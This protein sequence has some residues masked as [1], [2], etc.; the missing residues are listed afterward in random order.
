MERFEQDKRTEQRNNEILFGED[1]Q[2]SL[3]AFGTQAVMICRTS[4]LDN[5]EISLLTSP[6]SLGTSS[7]SP[8]TSTDSLGT[9]TDSLLTSTDSLLTSSDS[10]LTKQT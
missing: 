1:R 8:L 7:D 9:S 2:A 6:E 5:L 4:M 3:R 10:L